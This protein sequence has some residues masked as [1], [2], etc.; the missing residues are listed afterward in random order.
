MDRMPM[1]DVARLSRLACC[2]AHRL[3]RCV[4]LLSLRLVTVT[5]FEDKYITVTAHITHI[6]HVFAS[7]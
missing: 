3:L 2:V 1:S 7:T 6:Y 4:A 5:L